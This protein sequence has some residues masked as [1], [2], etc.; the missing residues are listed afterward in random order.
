MKKAI[1]VLGAIVSLG[2]CDIIS[3]CGDSIPY[4]HHNKHRSVRIAARSAGAL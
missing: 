3:P 4:E 1:S 2:R